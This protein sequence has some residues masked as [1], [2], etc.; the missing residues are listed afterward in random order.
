MLKN[1]LTIAWRNIV[2]TKGYSFINIC[3][4]A[5]GM[6]VAILIGLW[7]FDELNYNK[8]FKNYDR[9]GQIYH[10]VTFGEEILTINDVPAPIGEALKTNYAE[11]EDAAVASWPREHIIAYDETKLS[12]TGLFVEPQFVSMFSIQMTQGTAALTDIHSIILSR[13]LAASLFGDSPVG[14]MIKFDNRDLLMVTGVFEDFPSNSEF[15]DIKMLLP[16]GYYFTINDTNRKALNNWES[17][18]FQCF[19]LL[20]NETLFNQVEPK[21]KHVLYEKASND[22]KSIKPQGI[23]FPMKKWHLYGV[24][25]D[26]INT[27]GQIKFVWM[28]GIIGIF[29]LLL[30][31]INFTNLSTARSEKRS[32]E[33]GVRKVMGSARNQLVAQFLSESLLMVTIGFLLALAVAAFSLPWFNTL[34]DKKMAMPWRD[35]NFILISLAFIMIT[36]FLAGSYPALYLSS[37]SPVKVLKGTFKTSR[38]AALPRKVMVI[39][40]FTTSI[41]LIISTMVVFLQIQHAKDRPVG[42]DR[43]GILHIAVRTEALA[44]ASYNSLRNELLSSGAVENMALS[45][46]P[47][48]GA[49][50]ADA[51]LTW[52]GKDPALRPLVAMNSCSHDFPKT[53]GFQFVEGRDFS[54]EFSTDSSA[55]IIN[56]M[57]AKLISGKNIVGKKLTFHGKEREIIGVIKDQVRWTPFTK[58]SPHL[59]FIS[60]SGRG[61]ITVRLNPQV[62]TPEALQKIE[63]VIKRFDA[64]APFEYKFLDD[65]YARLFNNEERIGKL[66]TVFSILTIF[67]SCLGIFGLATFA[68]SQRTKE[69]GIRKVLGASIFALW[70]ML[71][72]DFLLLVVVAILLGAPLAYYLATQW[73]EQYE[74]RVEISWLI[75]VVTSILVV[76]ITLFTVSYQTLKAALANPMNSLRT[77]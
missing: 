35:P 70:R 9:L 14:K 24:F 34:A 61:Y 11:F 8:A 23:I 65:D 7:V 1:Y 49:M 72:A 53:N 66:A 41:V 44:R 56:E 16:L 60:Y 36:G 4:L 52:E 67:I 42:F 59:Y 39:F 26:G 22:G 30:A 63:A 74:Y 27:G 54:R 62:G 6:T 50:S 17:Y 58:Q 13:T 37:F 20:K 3:G 68:A 48:T 38:F 5:I 71:S 15:A 64:G 33:V 43:E 55:V 32:K 31:C 21:I 10:H 40:Q 57:A 47:I 28:F 25:K 29:V 19:V 75:F 46:F 45:D 69:I 77:E 73:L 51:S 76:L 18:A 2:R 12:K